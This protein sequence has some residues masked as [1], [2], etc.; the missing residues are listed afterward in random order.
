M[1]ALDVARIEAGLLLIEVDFFSS[2][3]AMIASQMYTPYELGMGRLVSLDKGRFIGQRALR[4]EQ[5]RGPARQIVGLAIDWNEVEKLYDAAGLAPAVAATASR[6]AVPVYGTDA[7]GRE[8]DVDHVV[9]GAQAHDRARR[10]RPSALRGGHRPAVRDGRR[11]RPSP[12][13]RRCGEGAFFGTARKMG[14]RRHG[15]RKCAVRLFWFFFALYALTSSGNPFRVPDE[16]EVYFQAEHLVD[17]GDISVPQTLAIQ[18]SGAPIFYGKFGLDGRPY[19]PYGPGVAYLLV[20]F[21]LAGRLVARLAHVPRAPLPEGSA[22]EFVVGGVT[23]LG[24]AFAAALAVAGFYRACL[25]LGAP[26]ELSLRLAAIL[27]GATILWPYGTTLYSEAW[28]AAAFS[29]AAALLLEARNGGSRAHVRVIG[30]AALVVT[31]GLTKPTALIVAPAFVVAVLIDRH[32]ERARAKVALALTAGIAPAAMLNLDGT[33]GVSA[34]RW[35]S[36]T[37]SAE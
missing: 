35:I 13:A 12:S 30:A 33:P 36:V 23:S 15:A 9:A 1:L 32:Q 20:P 27:G 31:A 29:W 16:F 34:A 24:M 11:G 2:R 21:H 14:T 3:K 19:A 18:E 7:P 10:R 26:P 37:T 8:G 22:W 28:L 6:A 4:E 17:A 25:A 5:Q